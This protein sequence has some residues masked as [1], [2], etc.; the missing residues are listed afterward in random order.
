MR[1][2]VGIGDGRYFGDYNP[3]RMENGRFRHD[4]DDTSVYTFDDDSSILPDSLCAG[5]LEKRVVKRVDDSPPVTVIVEAHE[6]TTESLPC[7]IKTLPMKI[8]T[9]S[10][11]TLE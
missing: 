3:D 8:H 5:Y 11:Y 9:F 10:A 6:D 2:V 4:A 7:Y 1:L